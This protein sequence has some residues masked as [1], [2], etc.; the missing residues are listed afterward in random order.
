MPKHLATTQSIKYIFT[1]GIFIVFGFLLFNYQEDFYIIRDISAWQFISVSLLILIGVTINGSKLNCISRNFGVHLRIRELFALSSMTTVLNNVFFKAGSVATSGYLKKKYNFS[2]SS[3]AGT[4]LGD[5][6]IIL[7][8]GSFFGAIVS[9]Y[10]GLFR[11]QD[12]LLIFAGFALIAALLFCLMRG[13]IRL[14]QIESSIFELLKRGTESF[15][16]LLHD[17]NLLHSL[18]ALNTFLIITIGFRLYVTC[19][20]L[21]MEI[22]LSHCFLFAIAII[23]ARIIP[24]T[25]NDIGVRELAVG[26]L[27]DILGSGLKAGVL[28]TVVDWIFE[29]LWTALCTGFFRNSLVAPND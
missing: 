15:N 6:L 2:Y 8:I 17:K 18:G 23:F 12:L 20:I 29:L 26:F 22:P 10:L 19:S 4:F 1:A 7:F 13:G 9:L 25:H 14:P 27:S 5:Q 24:I 28:A 11:H 21:H 16:T 3:F